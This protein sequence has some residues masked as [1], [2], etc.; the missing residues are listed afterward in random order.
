MSNE[1]EETSGH[2]PTAASAG[3]AAPSRPSSAPR[4]EKP[5]KEKYVVERIQLP[6]DWDN[7]WF[8][9][10]RDQLANRPGFHIFGRCPS[11]HHQTTAV[12]ATDYLAQGIAKEGGDPTRLRPAQRL[13]GDY[14]TSVRDFLPRFTS[15]RP[16]KRDTT[17]GLKAQITV[18]RCACLE[19]HGP[20]APGAFGCGSE[21]LLRVQYNATDSEKAT[22]IPVS[23]EEASR[24]WPAADAAFA[25]ATGSLTLAE[26]SAKNWGA[27]LTTILTLL[28]ISGLLASRS[29]V[30]SLPSPWKV[31]FGIAAFV[32][33][34]SDALML[35]Q[36]NFASYGSPRI[37]DALKSSDAENADLDP[38]MQA[39][40]SVRKLQIAVRAAA[41]S[42]ISALFAAGILLFA[43]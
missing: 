30:Q 40:T 35:Y 21:W 32:A 18:V 34:L 36:T 2:R 38:L 24:C 7:R 13:R 33:V 22:L 5:F 37:T 1:A 17:S 28:G 39:R 42:G 19:N 16:T 43:S 27:A 31:V 9:N 4:L 23:A 14:P 29:S 10:D 11:C 15:W 25:E 26:A 20:P 41:V 6:G 12:C 8:D 3:P